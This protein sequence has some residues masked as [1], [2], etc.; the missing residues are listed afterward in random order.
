M[1]SYLDDDD[2][3]IENTAALGNPAKGLNQALL[4]LTQEQWYVIGWVPDEYHH[5]DI[6][7]ILINNWM[8][9]IGC[10]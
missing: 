3:N 8:F 4:C 6:S 5:L 2:D 7:L 10:G 1:S 9:L